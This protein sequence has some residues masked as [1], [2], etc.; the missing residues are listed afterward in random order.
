MGSHRRDDLPAE[1]GS[2]LRRYD[3]WQ[4]WSLLSY[5]VN[6]PRRRQPGQS[7]ERWRVQLVFRPPHRPG[8]GQDQGP[9]DGGNRYRALDGGRPA[10]LK[11]HRAGL[12]AGTTEIDPAGGGTFRFT[13]SYRRSSSSGGRA[14]TKTPGS[15]RPAAS[16]GA[17]RAVPTSSFTKTSRSAGAPI[18][19]GNADARRIPMPNS[20]RSP[21]RKPPGYSRTGPSREGPIPSTNRAR[22]L[23]QRTTA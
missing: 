23:H 8:E 13:P 2:P 5:H 12:P 11:R 16:V 19:G 7:R 10:P 20:M 21:R 18:P 14:K 3:R 22:L 15:S 9:K 6:C 1:G 17:R 4:Q